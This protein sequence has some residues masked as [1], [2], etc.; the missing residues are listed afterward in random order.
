MSFGGADT[1]GCSGGAGTGGALEEQSWL[2]QETKEGWTGPAG[3][4]VDE[5]GLDGV[6]RDEIELGFWP[7]PVIRLG[8]WLSSGEHSEV[9]SGERIGADN[10]G[11]YAISRST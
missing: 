5:G 1:V 9:D 11:G 4:S 8:S 2:T 10:S 6:S 3:D 7:S